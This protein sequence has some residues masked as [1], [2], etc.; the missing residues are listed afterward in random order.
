[1]DLPTISRQPLLAPE[2]STP[3]HIRSRR[4]QK[5]HSTV[6]LGINSSHPLRIV[7]LYAAMRIWYIRLYYAVWRHYTLTH[8]V[9][10]RLDLSGLT[11]E[12]SPTCQLKLQ[13]SL[14]FNT[15]SPSGRYSFFLISPLKQPLLISN[16]FSSF[17][18]CPKVD[19][20]PVQDV[21]TKWADA[22]SSA[23]PLSHAPQPLPS[24]ASP[25]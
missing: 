20:C 12:I 2:G 4:E 17:E 16:P 25:S 21:V 1:M 7:Q 8:T 23:C 14:L 10:I 6:M 11:T 5:K 13:S 24:P 22:S 18:R 9:Y 3:F 15:L 19:V